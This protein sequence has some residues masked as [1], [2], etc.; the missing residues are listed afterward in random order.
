MDIPKAKNILSNYFA[1]EGKHIYHIHQAIHGI[2]EDEMKRTLTGYV[3]Y[4]LLKTL[5]SDIGTEASG[6]MRLSAS[7]EVDALWH[8]HVMCT[9][10][11]LTFMGKVREVNPL[12][13]TLH[14]SLQ[15]SLDTDEVK[16]KRRQATR[17]AYRRV[18]GTECSWLAIEE[19]TDIKEEK[20]EEDR[21]VDGERSSW[22]QSHF[23]MVFVKSLTGKIHTYQIKQTTTIVDF[24]RKIQLKEGIPPDDQRLIFNGKQLQDGNTVGYYNIKHNCTVHNVLKLRAC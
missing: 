19:N 7:P 13:D 23:I 9:E 24:K 5:A 3:E 14:H 10:Q 16:A 12:V 11:Y 20:P 15:G 6:G 17:A 2:H 22:N 18:F 21:V 4:I 8:T 1:S